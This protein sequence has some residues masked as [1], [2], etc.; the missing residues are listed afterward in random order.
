MNGSLDV[1]EMGRPVKAH[2]YAKEVAGAGMQQ[3]LTPW[4]V[5]KSEQEGP[6]LTARR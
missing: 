3:M 6:T 4:T 1:L 5:S 2:T